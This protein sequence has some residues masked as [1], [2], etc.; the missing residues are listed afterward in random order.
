MPAGKGPAASGSFPLT[1]SCS[2]R[3]LASA[4]SASSRVPRKTVSWIFAVR[5]S[6]SNGRFPDQVES[7]VPV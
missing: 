3:T 2:R 5:A 6:R 4:A 1:F 7:I